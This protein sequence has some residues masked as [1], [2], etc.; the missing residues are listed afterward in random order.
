MKKLLFIMLALV[1]MSSVFADVIIGTGTST[2]RYPLNDYFV[3]SRSQCI[4]LAS[5]IN[6]TGTITHLQWY[7]NDT[8]ADPSAIGTTEIWLTTTASTTL[9]TWQTPGTL[10]KTISN[11]DLGAGGGWYDVDIDDFAYSGSNL[12]VTVRT[13]N[14]PY[15]TPHSYWRY[16]TTATYMS[17]LGNSDGTNPPDVSTSYYRPN[18]KLVGIT[19]ATPPGPANLVSPLNGGTG[20]LPIATMNWTAGAGEP[21]GYKLQYG[22]NPAGDNL[23][24]LTDI[25]NILSYDPAGTFTYGQT[26]Y[27]KVVPYNG[28]GDC[29]TSVVWSFTIQNNVTTYPYE[30]GF[31]NAGVLP[32]DWTVAEGAAGASRHWAMTTAD[33][34]HGAAADHTADPGTYFAYLYC[35]LASTTYNPYYLITP[36]L[37]LGATPRQLQYWYWIG[38]DSF[39]NP[40]Y[41]DVSTNG[42]S[43][44]ELYAHSNATNTLAWYQ[45]TV[46]LS[47]YVNQTVYLRFRGMSSYGDY[48]TDF[49][50]D[51]IAVNDL[52]S[53]PLAPS[54][55]IPGDT[56][57]GIS[58]DSDLAWTNNGNTTKVDVYFSTSLT[59]VTN[60]DVSVRVANDQTSPLNS[61]VLGTLNDVYSTPYYWRVVAKNNAG[62]SSVDGPV[63]SFTTMADPTINIPPNYAETFDGVTAPAMPDNWTVLNPDILHSY[64]RTINYNYNTSPNCLAISYSYA[65]E[66]PLNDWA[67]TPP[68]GLTAGYEYQLKFKYR[69]GSVDTYFENLGVYWGD[70]PTAAALTNNLFTAASFAE[71]NYVDVTVSFTP[72]TT[73]IYYIGWYAYS[74]EDQLNICVDD[75]EI[76]YIPIA[77]PDPVTLSYPGDGATGLPSTGFNLTWTQAGTGGVPDDYTVY[78]SLTEEDIYSSWTANTSNLYFN[79][80]TETMSPPFTGYVDGQDYFW[81]I[82]ANKETFPSAVVEPPHKFTIAPV[83]STIILNGSGVLNDVTLNWLPYTAD[84]TLNWDNSVTGN[85]IGYGTYEGTYDVAVRF[86]TPMLADYVGQYITKL[87]IWPYEAVADGVLLTLKV[88]SGSDGTYTPTGSPIFSQPVT[89]WTPLAWNDIT[90]PGIAITGT[91]ALWIGYE[92]YQPATTAGLYPAGCDGGPAVAGY[93]DL[94][95]ESGVWSSLYEQS[96]GGLNYNWH[97]V[98]A[99]TP[100]AR[101]ELAQLTHI[102]APQ[103]TKMINKPQLVAVNPTAAPETDR[104][105]TGY[106][107]YRN[108]VPLNVTPIFTT[109][110]S[111]PDLPD[112]NYTYYVKAEYLNN[113]ATVQSNDWEYSYFTAPPFAL[114][115][116][117]GWDAGTYTD[118]YWATEGSN[119]L[120]SSGVGQPEPSAQFY[121]SPSQTDYSMALT[122]YG[123]V[124]TGHA[125]IWLTLD[126]AL[127]NYSLTTEEMM[128]IDVWNGSAWVTLQTISNQDYATDYAAFEYLA[129]DIT[130]Y[131]VG[132]D[133]QIRFVAHGG[134][135][136]NIDNW[137][138]DNINV[139]ELP[140]SL[141]TPEPVTITAADPDVLL[142]W[143]YVAGA[144]YYAIY[145]SNDPY[146]VFTYFGYV[147]GGY[148]GVYITTEPYKFFKVSAG[149]GALP[150]ARTELR[151]GIIRH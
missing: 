44:T 147:S 19:S 59:L 37:T 135:S 151:R 56:M 34:T 115:F 114:P 95:G 68:L 148:N 100:T 31:E 10:V 113:T 119:W 125:N 55:P 12:M 13:Q 70:A 108:D 28:N 52:P 42:T 62:R 109:T 75:I 73:D 82:E 134:N 36:P 142:G 120:I 21:T 27:W 25:N 23:M 105:F 30:I 98:G 141:D 128:D 67:I 29:T 87:S 146:G 138:I 90:I 150:P 69:G 144:T 4:Y 7:R 121:Y 20:I 129:Y 60:K 72:E 80:V 104:Y 85:A 61:F 93:G 136:F 149:A 117:E 123:M 41:V 81:T 96:S 33:A 110:Y 137:Y 107:V 17:L 15:T 139:F 79:P 145:A 35:Y 9:S 32:P 57:T 97:I 76:R 8:G 74:I 2:G 66:G 77:P 43:W 111:D 24:A 127:D 99:V 83:F 91:E 65:G 122:S 86:E 140:A 14:A 78:L 116:F 131:A 124:G 18:I 58:M 5:E 132:H 51:D 92:I 143:E 118:Q 39:A 102:L 49:G 45:N 3:Y 106:T 22:T 84:G 89:T 47:G 38:D 6:A 88:W 48:M 126:L 53:D 54:N 64:W 26:Y 11:I 94:I 46:S 63:W 16:T 112:G 71:P 101:G 103:P 133:F 130:A 1:L 50:L 40:L